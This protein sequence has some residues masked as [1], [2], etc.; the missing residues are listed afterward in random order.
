MWAWPPWCA[1]L[2]ALHPRLG[3]QERSLEVF[4]VPSWFWTFHH[5]Y[6]R[7]LKELLLQSFQLLREYWDIPV[8][9]TWQF[10]DCV[11]VFFGDASFKKPVTYFLHHAICSNHTDDEEGTQDLTKVKV[12]EF[13]PR[14]LLFCFGRTGLRGTYEIY[15]YGVA[16]WFLYLVTSI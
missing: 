12:T 14:P 16:T 2:Y 11:K 1:C 3:R 6:V 9:F 10:R 7:T 5:W 4:W 15:L 8:P 13:G